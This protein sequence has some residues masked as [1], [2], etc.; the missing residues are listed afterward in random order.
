MNASFSQLTTF[1]EELADCTELLAA[2]KSLA[3]FHRELTEGLKAIEN[4][5]EP[6]LLEGDDVRGMCPMVE[7]LFVLRMGLT[8]VLDDLGIDEIRG[9]VKLVSF[10]GGCARF[11][12]SWTMEADSAEKSLQNALNVF[13]YLED[14]LREELEYAD[15]L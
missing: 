8:V 4:L 2:N 5:A 12:T 7:A 6:L 14:W 10:K 9:T 15:S 3:T 1:T 13:Q 11:E